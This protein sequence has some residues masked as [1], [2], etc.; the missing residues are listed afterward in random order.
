ERFMLLLATSILIGLVVARL[1]YYFE[2]KVDDASIEITITLIAP[3]FAYLAAEAAHSSGVLATVT[4]GLYLGHKSSLYLSIG[5]RL[6]GYA[7][8]ETLTFVLNGF[9]FI[10][11]GLQL[12]YV[13]EGIHEY[14]L[15]RLLFLGA[16]FSAGVILLRLVWA[17]PGALAS[18]FIRRRLLHQDE[19]LPRLRSVFIVGWTG[20]RG[21]VALAAAISL[22]EYLENGSPFPQR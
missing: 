21:V 20:M 10:L 6:R 12:P 16:I 14:T 15:S 17:Y 2:K 22:P 19:P 11:I 8:W 7:V 9:V 5:A 1:I 4:C 13:L 18:N 3:Y